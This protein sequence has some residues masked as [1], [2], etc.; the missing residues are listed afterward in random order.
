MSFYT[1]NGVFTREQIEDEY[2]NML[3]EFKPY[4]GDIGFSWIQHMKTMS[5][6]NLKELI[7]QVKEWKR[8]NVRAFSYNNK[9]FEIDGRKWYVLIAQPYK[10]EEMEECGTC[11]VS[12]LL[13]NTWVNGYTYAFDKESNRDLIFQILNGEITSKICSICFEDYYGYG[14]NAYPVHLENVSSRCCDKCNE[15]IVIPARINKIYQDK[16]KEEEKQVEKVRQELLSNPTLIENVLEIKKDK[17]ETQKEKTRQANK[18]KAKEKKLK[19][20]QEQKIAISQANA[21]EQRLKKQRETQKKKKQ[22]QLKEYAKISS[23]SSE[24]EY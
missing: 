24:E 14:N 3:Y 20:D 6:F 21:H 22:A 16:I 8:I 13:F 18:I 5:L 19:R 7:A 23:S 4:A 11:V 12:M 1:N 15:T 2:K 17:K 10:D 9:E